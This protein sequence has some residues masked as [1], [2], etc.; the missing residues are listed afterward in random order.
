MGGDLDSSNDVDMFS[1]PH[2][3][4]FRWEN[5]PDGVLRDNCMV[6]T[7]QLANTLI[8]NKIPEN[9]PLYLAGGY[10]WNFVQR[11]P[12]FAPLTKRY[13]VVMKDSL[14]KDGHLTVNQER[15]EWFA[16]ID[17]EICREA[18]H[19]IG[20][21]VSTFSAMLELNRLKNNHDTFHYN[22]GNIPL[23]EML[24]I[25]RTAEAAGQQSA[26]LKWIFSIFIGNGSKDS[27]LAMAKVAV[28]SAQHRT[29]L[30]PFC[31]FNVAPDASESV[32]GVAANFLEWLQSR[33][34]TI[35]YHKPRW[36]YKITETVESGKAA[37]NIKYS[38]LYKDAAMMIATFTRFDIPVLGFT[39]DY[40][41]YADVDVMFV[42]DIN[43]ASFDAL[44]KYMLC[45]TESQK[46]G[47]LD[48]SKKNFYAN[49]GIILYNMR[50]MRS[51]HEEFINF[52]FS[53]D[54]MERGL[55][56]GK[57]GPG[58]QG[59]YNQFYDGLMTVVASAPFNYKP[60]WEDT[61]EASHV[62]IVHWHGPKA[63]DYDAYLTD[64]KKTVLYEPYKGIL[65]KC[66][67]SSNAG[68][69]AKHVGH[70]CFKWHQRWN[71]YDRIVVTGQRLVKC[72]DEHDLCGPMIFFADEQKGTRHRISSCDQCSGMLTL[73]CKHIVVV[74][75]Q[76][77]E[78]L[79]DKGVFNCGLLNQ[80]IKPMQEQA[81]MQKLTNQITLDFA[82]AVNEKPLIDHELP[83]TRVYIRTSSVSLP[84]L[85]TCFK[86]ANG[87]AVTVEGKKTTSE[88]Y[89]LPEDLAAVAFY[90]QIVQAGWSTLTLQEAEV[91]YIASFPTLS[92]RVGEC[93]GTSHAQRQDEVF[94][95]LNKEF[96]AEKVKRQRRGEL[97]P[98]TI[99]ACTSR[100]CSSPLKRTEWNMLWNSNAWFLTLE[101]NPLWISAD[102]SEGWKYSKS[103]VEQRAIPVPYTAHNGI[104]RTDYKGK[105]GFVF[106]GNQYI[107][108]GKKGESTGHRREEIL[109]ALTKLKHAGL[110]K[111]LIEWT[112][113]ASTDLESQ[114]DYAEEMMRGKF[115]FVPS[116]EDGPTS[117][118]FFDAV[119]AGC[120]PIVIGDDIDKE[121][122][123]RDV[124]L[125]PSFWFRIPE[126]TWI[127]DPVG[128]VQMISNVPADVITKR[129]ENM[130]MFTPLLDWASGS[131]TSLHILDQILLLNGLSKP[132]P[133][134]RE[135]KSILDSFQHLFHSGPSLE[136][137]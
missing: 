100:H 87:H 20:N 45:G 68:V 99:F 84:V 74:S 110:D 9:I 65:A 51:S 108:T 18:R 114:V 118:R 130:D 112:N 134:I 49:A 8:T 107:A 82:D 70:T 81:V 22:T 52:A 57:F 53:D 21:S 2:V 91:V 119:V 113:S 102:T 61:M 29:S 48:I 132:L 67:C 123:L 1:R 39:D 124:I 36:A 98:V 27:Y 106:I 90:E 59:A 16:F 75:A 7:D 128:V 95:W 115:C 30:D 71:M 58:D 92:E 133:Q 32:K 85:L 44:P 129:Q 43:L 111:I 103:Y 125:Y 121:L 86:E 28:T 117:R 72:I 17:Y 38:P 41:L 109:N 42:S 24:P 35:I 62:S 25:R 33:G 79:V 101:K 50:F 13:T 105:V 137:N 14:V 73:L 63:A 10:T 37:Q 97:P 34:V 47:T 23:E 3:L 77:L 6:N 31:I 89:Y 55:H 69:A 64:C 135:K 80:D 60:Y 54:S 26:R 46:E 66:S 93:A 120:L 94:S 12:I 19:F 5:I 136:P 127:N 83:P 116:I 96:A 11:S 78:S 122:P 88:E 104:Q 40:V 131:A 4:S 76:V 56:Y 15:R 126:S